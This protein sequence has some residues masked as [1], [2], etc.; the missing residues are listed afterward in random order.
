M[1]KLKLL[2]IAVIGLLLLNFGM[3][4]MMYFHHHEGPPFPP[5]GGPHEGPKMIIIEKLHFDE[6]QVKQYEV[7][8][9]DHR[10]KSD[11]LNRR[12]HEL[13]DQLYSLLKDESI[14][15]AKLSS[16]YTAIGEN[17]RA[18]EQINFEHFQKIKTLCKPDQLDAFN[19]LVDELTELFGQKGP[20]GRP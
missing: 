15:A 14:D 11:S 19:N 8:I 20:P 18:I 5:H 12:S 2:T 3:L 16:T 17:Q 13:R 4:G 1:N 10:S 6:S 7:M 9:R